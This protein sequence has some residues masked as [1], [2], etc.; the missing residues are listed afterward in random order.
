MNFAAVIGSILAVSTVLLSSETRAAENA[1]G[2]TATEV[3]IG[4]T[5][6][7]SGPASAFANTGRGLLVYV[8]ALNERGGVGGRKINMVVLDDA[9]SPPKAVE[10]TRK[11]VEGEEVA[12]I[13]SAI[14]TPSNAATIK[15]LNTKKVPDLFIV[16]GASRFSNFSE[17]P[18][19][20]TALPSYQTEGSIYAR[21][22]GDSF[23]NDRIAILYQNDDLGKDF[24]QAFKDRFKETFA[25]K[26]TA[27]SYE[28]T[29]PTIESQ[30]VNLKEA[31][32]GVFLIAGTPK[33]AAQAIR[34]SHE[35]G[36]KPQIILN[37]VSS[38]I[39]STLR[40]VGLDISAGIVS[41]TYYKD[42]ADPQFAGDDSV[43]EF[44]RLMVKFAPNADTSDINYI[45]GYNQGAILEQLLKQCG[46][47]LSRDNIMKQA[48]NIRDLVLPMTIP[49]IVVNTD[50][51][52]SQAITQLKLERWTGTEWQGFGDVVSAA[53]K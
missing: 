24:L 9:Y 29:D 25:S 17:F 31:G 11:L 50:A 26:V 41:A 33:F 38:S 6:P 7:L 10:Q 4:S 51:V 48:R 2:I 45:T 36:W 39:S 46:D 20:T 3:K 19:T 28:I 16:S 53:P 49:G 27:L 18:Y 34:K 40:P 1:P 8:D 47:D 14:G 42:P 44:K 52:N 5:F 37:L 12:F 43:K 21:Y 35:L 22:A 23:P 13:Y 32:A 15:Y 30:V